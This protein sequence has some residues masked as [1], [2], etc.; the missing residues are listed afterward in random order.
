MK[1]K[2]SIL[3]IY[4][5]STSMARWEVEAGESPEF[6]GPDSLAGTMPNENKEKN[7]REEN[8]ETSS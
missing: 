3:C 1:D 2:V 7:G 4:N 8:R 5:P 6:Q